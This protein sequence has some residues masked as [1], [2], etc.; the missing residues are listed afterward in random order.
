VN[1]LRIVSLVPSLTHLLSDLGLQEQIAGCTKFCVQ[2]PDLHRS[3]ILCGG[4]KDPDLMK[5]RD[6]SPTH[7]LV[8]EEENK[9]EHIRELMTISPVLNTFPK[10]PA[11]VPGLID[12]VCAFLG[13]RDDQQLSAHC[14]SLIAETKEHARRQPPRRFAYFIWKNPW[15]VVSRDTYISRFLELLGWSNV[16]EAADRY[17]T[18]ELPL[19]GE[20]P[21]VL[22]LSTEPWPFRQRDL[23]DLAANW[24]E[25]PP[26]MKADGMLCSWYGSMLI[27]AL[28]EAKKYCRGEPQQ[29]FNDIG[30]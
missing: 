9:P 27:P 20:R 3:A 22:L 24:P 19:T 18:V 21:D 30:K 16:I 7:I 17:P 28:E 2:P 13:V 11:D 12:D 10:G 5:I 15:M 6:L 8:N 29:L 26:V 25:H 4:T 23:K 1:E 14:R